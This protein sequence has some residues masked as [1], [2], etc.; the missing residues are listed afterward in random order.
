[1]AT[2]FNTML[3]NFR[4]VLH[5]VQCRGRIGGQRRR[6]DFGQRRRP[7]ESASARGE[8]ISGSS[9]ATEELT[10]SIARW[11]PTPRMCATSPTRAWHRRWHL[12]GRR[13]GAGDAP[14]PGAGRIHRR[15]GPGFRRQHQYHQRHDPA[16]QGDRRPDQ[17]P[18]L[19]AAIE[20][21]R[22]GEQGRG[23]AV[24][25]DEVRKLAENRPVR[26]TRSSRSPAASRT[27]PPRFRRH[28][29]RPHSIAASV[30]KAG[31]VDTPSAWPGTT[32]PRPT[33]ASTTSANRC[34]TGTGQHRDRPGHGKIAQETD[35]RQRSPARSPGRPGSQP[36]RQPAARRRQPL[37]DRLSEP[38]TGG[39]RRSAA[40]VG[41]G[42]M[43]LLPNTGPIAMEAEH[44]NAISNQLD[45]LAQR[46]AELRR[47]L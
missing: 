7:Y 41:A 2:S 42:I 12:P 14:H 34:R 15:L 46:A 5:Q 43:T 13:A 3:T 32:W 39:R 17:P 9:A 28:P 29:E 33:G 1:M 20:A 6:A 35:E 31:E 21:A 47:Y 16:G 45:D 24:V 30:A 40:G 37:Q 4:A 11:R 26:P 25:A 10:V 18:G 22:A 27:S 23:F 44:Q 36:A 38:S 8:S 19:N